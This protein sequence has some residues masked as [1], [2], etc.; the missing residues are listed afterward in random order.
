MQSLFYKEMVVKRDVV[1][2]ASSLDS[3]ESVKDCCSCGHSSGT[4]SGVDSLVATP[5]N[6][7]LFKSSELAKGVK[8]VEELMDES[9]NNQV[10]SEI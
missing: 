7:I 6:Q 2:D 8:D 10:D 5:V 1:E 3:E 4:E 9:E